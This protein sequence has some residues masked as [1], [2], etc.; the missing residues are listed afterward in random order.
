MTTQ[1]FTMDCL[2]VIEKLDEAYQWLCKQRN[3]A[4]VNSDVWDL[5]FNW[6]KL[7]TEIIEKL[8]NNLYR[9][10]AVNTFVINGEYVEQWSASDALVLKALAMCLSETVNKIS[11]DKCHNVKGNGGSKAAIRRI[12]KKERI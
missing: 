10:D 1:E 11:S 9:F 6:N 8:K 2:G 4:S 3:D 12:L 5:R 7:R